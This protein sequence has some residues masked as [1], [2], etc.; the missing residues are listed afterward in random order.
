MVATLSEFDRIPR[1]LRLNVAG[2]P[3]DW[4]T[5][6]DAVCLYTR[7]IVI[8]TVGDPVMRIR[9]GH[10]RIDGMPS[11]VD[12]HSIIACDGRVVSKEK[13]IPPLT[14]QAL[15]GRDRNTCMYCGNGFK[16]GELTRDHVMPVSKGGRDTWDNVVAACKRCNHYKGNRVLEELNMELLALPYVPNFS[17]YLALINSGRILGDQMDFLKKSFGA[18]SRLLH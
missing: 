9:G 5:W 12:I 16:D 18:Q 3:L 11:S 15:F 8:W 17:E 4:V 7:E 10:S 14:N 13:A 2:Q 1:I 6:Q